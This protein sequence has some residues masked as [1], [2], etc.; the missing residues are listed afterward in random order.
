MNSQTNS[1]GHG[2]NILFRW[3][4]VLKGNPLQELK[5]TD[6][7]GRRIS[8]TH[9]S[10]PSL[11]LQASI[12]DQLCIRL[13]HPR[14]PHGPLRDKRIT[15][16]GLCVFVLCVCVCLCFCAFSNAKT[17]V[18]SKPFCF[19]LLGSKTWWGLKSRLRFVFAVVFVIVCV[20]LDL[21]LCVGRH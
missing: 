11:P 3:Q 20:V 12:E 5:K 17:V 8:P 7:P 19:W 1:S 21:C 9:E 13:C 15:P 10:C 14:S 16:R 6:A 4:L 2:Q 18:A